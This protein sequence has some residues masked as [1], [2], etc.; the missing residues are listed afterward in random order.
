MS[1]GR[2]GGGINIGGGGLYN[3]ADNFA[4]AG[5]QFNSV[6]DRV[7]KR[8]RDATIRDVLNAKPEE[9]QDADTFRQ[10]QLQKLLVQNNGIDPLDAMKISDA[11]SKPY[12]DTE[13]KTLAQVLRAEDLGIAKTN[14]DRTY[15]AN[16]ITDG[17]GQVMQIDPTTGQ[18]TTP[19]GNAKPMASKGFG[20]FTDDYGKSWKY[21]KDDGTVTIINTGTYDDGSGSNVP[22]KYRQ[23]VQ[24]KDRDG[25]GNETVKQV[26][27]DKRNGQ[28]INAGEST[29][30]TVAPTLSQKDKDFT[31]LYGQGNTTIGNVRGTLDDTGIWGGF[32]S[33]VQGIGAFFNTDAGNK[34]SLLNQDLENLRLEATSKLSGVLS[35]QDMQIIL[36]TIPTSSDQPEVARTKLAKVEKAMADADANQFNRLVKSNKAAV[37]DMAIGMVNGTTPVPTGYQLVQYDDGAVALIPK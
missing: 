15:G 25:L 2:V 17:A 35:N 36:D 1:L 28:P 11:S 7:A 24:V 8:E 37:K 9:G 22:A 34:G 10:S 29:T 20:T 3:P 30:G 23:V 5:E 33:K 31:K 19:V 14:A 13:A 6:F 18:Y 27:I 16:T 26:V 4:A 21:N 12:F 32:D